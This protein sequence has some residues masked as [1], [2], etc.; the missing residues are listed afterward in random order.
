MVDASDVS[1]TSE[2]NV[3]DSGGHRHPGGLRQDDAAQRTGVVEAD[4]LGRLPLTLRDAL[5]RRADD[6]GRVATDVEAERDHRGGE[7]FEFDPELG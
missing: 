7:R 1:L 5:D 6:L 3:F 4:G 2:I